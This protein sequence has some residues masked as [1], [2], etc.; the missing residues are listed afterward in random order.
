MVYYDI[1]FILIFLNFILLAFLFFYSIYL[2]ALEKRVKS[3]Y[4]EL[5]TKTTEIIEEANRKAIEI[6][7][8]SEFISDDLKGEI[9]T[10]FEGILQQIKDQNMSFYADLKTHYEK[11]STEIMD[12]LE[13]ET[14]EEIEKIS[15]KSEQTQKA[16]QNK[17]EEEA[18]EVEVE[19]ENEKKVKLEAF[20]LQI[21]AIIK[22]NLKDIVKTNIPEE[23]HEKIA[24]ESVAKALAEIKK[25]G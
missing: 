17:L 14:T 6:L 4:R 2:F 7:K 10:N 25:N 9:D 3:K 18:R 23:I 21:R 16:I 5:T 11:N 12:R 24:K 20:E 22:Q 19:L 15:Q 8:K 13:K 1:Q